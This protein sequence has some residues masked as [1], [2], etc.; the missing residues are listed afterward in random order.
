MQSTVACAKTA[1]TLFHAV[2][3]LSFVVLPVHAT[4]YQVSRPH[5]VGWLIIDRPPNT[6][7]NLWSFPSLYFCI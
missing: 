2:P 3:L 1:S 5:L 6:L 7:S 4:T